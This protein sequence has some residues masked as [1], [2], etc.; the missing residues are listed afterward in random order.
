M[1]L[2]KTVQE[3]SQTMTAAEETHWQALYRE[4]PFGYTRS[5][6]AAG[7]IVQM[8]HNTNVKQQDRKKLTDFLLFYRKPSVVQ[9]DVAD[10]VRSFFGKLVKKD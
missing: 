3:L 6:M 9:E 1:E 7:Q 8:L 10:N 5:D 4:E 2:G